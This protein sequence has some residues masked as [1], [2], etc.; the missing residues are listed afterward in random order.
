MHNSNKLMDLAQPKLELGSAKLMGSAWPSSSSM[1]NSNKLMNLA[2]PKLDAPD[3]KLGS[4]GHDMQVGSV[5]EPD[6]KVVDNTLS[7]D[8]R[9]AVWE[10]SSVLDW[11]LDQHKRVILAR[12]ERT[13]QA[14]ANMLKR[15]LDPSFGCSTNVGS[16]MNAGSTAF[17]KSCDDGKW[18]R[19]AFGHYI[20]SEGKGYVVEVAGRKVKTNG[21]FVDDSFSYPKTTLKAIETAE[22]AMGDAYV[23]LSL[24]MSAQLTELKPGSFVWVHDFESKIVIKL[25]RRRVVHVFWADNSSIIVESDSHQQ[26]LSTIHEWST[27][28]R[29]AGEKSVMDSVVF[30]P[31]PMGGNEREKALIHVL[32]V[33]GDRPIVFEDAYAKQD[34]ELAV[35][36]AAL[37]KKKMP[38]SVAS[39]TTAAI[40]TAA[41]PTAASRGGTTEHEDD[42][43]VR[44]EN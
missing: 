3:T 35:V 43:W 12:A 4:V 22:R 33:D 17:F 44:D 26:P 42:E 23:R 37:A 8:S 25:I 19:A 2:Q 7:V 18:Y 34:A 27:N 11:I 28:Y 36:T 41:G 20:V 5:V 38:A 31:S 6:E 13:K 21:I 32:N 10:E 15:F 14:S 1:H 29:V 40:Q 16:T 24:W 9:P 30:L 39:L